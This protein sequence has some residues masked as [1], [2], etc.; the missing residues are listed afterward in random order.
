MFFVSLEEQEAVV[1]FLVECTAIVVMKYSGSVSQYKLRMFISINLA[2]AKDNDILSTGNGH[3]QFNPI[4]LPIL[5]MNKIICFV[6]S[7][8]KLY[9][10]SLFSAYISCIFCHCLRFC[11]PGCHQM[12]GITL[13]SFSSA[14]AFST[15]AL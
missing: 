7:V 14:V 8:S 10:Q 9:S 4:P 15:V 6:G 1:Q 12:N 5:I 3:F 2:D 11:G 13:K